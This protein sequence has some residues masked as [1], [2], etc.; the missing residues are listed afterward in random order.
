M[1]LSSSIT[2]MPPEPMMDPSC[3]QALVIHR[4][5]EHLVRD[6]TAG[7]AAGLHCFDL[8]PRRAP[9]PMS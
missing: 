8:R 9:S 6:A 1:Q 7:G 3:C 4:G 5:I 2:T